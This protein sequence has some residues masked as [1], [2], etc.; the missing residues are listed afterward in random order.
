L[1]GLGVIAH[2]F[3]HSLGLPDIYPMYQSDYFSIVDDWDLMDGGNY[4]NRGWCPPNLSAMEKMYLKWDTPEEL[5]Q[6]TTIT[7]MK[8]VSAGGKSYIIRNSGNPNEYYLM[9]NHQQD[10]WDYGCPGNG[11]LIYHVNYLESSWRNNEVNVSNTFFRYDLF[12]A[13]GK[14]YIDWDPNNDGSAPNKYTMPDCM[15]SRY[16]S[17]SPYPYTNPSTLVVNN[18]LSDESSPVAMLFNRNADGL[19]LMGKSITNIQQAPDGTISFDFMKNGDSGIEML[20]DVRSKLSDAWYTIDGRRLAGR[21]TAKG[22]YILRPASGS[23]GKK[24]YLQ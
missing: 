20:S 10:G 3:C 2:E 22:M 14:S 24:I 21:P 1:C 16:L 13:D 19:L 17:T 23:F 9:E 5:T 15:R 11:L 8:S 4:I 12:H 7:G 18:S 6:P